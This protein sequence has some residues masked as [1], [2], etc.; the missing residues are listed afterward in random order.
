MSNPG[1]PSVPTPVMVTGQRTARAPPGPLFG[2]SAES[3]RG[4]NMVEE[5]CRQ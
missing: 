1:S 4:L 5:L 3:G 2:P